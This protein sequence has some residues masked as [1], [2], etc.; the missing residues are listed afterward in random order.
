MLK[1]LVITAIYCLATASQSV[2]RLAKLETM[3]AEQ[4]AAMTEQGV[5]M[6]QALQEIEQLKRKLAGTRI[7]I[8]TTSS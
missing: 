2:D 3:V 6:Q 1:F 4:Q 7:N 8:I 5:V